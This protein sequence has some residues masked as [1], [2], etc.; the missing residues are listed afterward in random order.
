MKS[1][2]KVFISVDWGTSNFRMRA[3]DTETLQVLGED[4]NHTG[5]RTLYEQVV[6]T[7]QQHRQQVFT[8][9]LRDRLH[10]L[11]G[12]EQEAPLIISGMASS[13]I[14]MLE[15]PYASCPIAVDHCSLQ[16]KQINLWDQR[17]AILVSG[18]SGADGIM[19]G[20]EVQA[21]GL[22]KQ[23][24][25]YDQA[26]LLL[27]GTHS[28]HLIWQKGEFTSFTSFMTGEL[29]EIL[30]RRSILAASIKNGVWTN[31]T[32]ASFM[33]GVKDGF[34]GRLSRSLFKVRVNEVL[35]RASPE[36]GY[37]LLSGLLIG[38]E[39]AHLKPS[40]QTIVLAAT[41]PLFSLYQLALQSCFPEEQLSFC[42]GAALEK[43]LLLGQKKI[44]SWYE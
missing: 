24:Q 16:W 43:A 5:V 35:H 36:Q 27:P 18:V 1:L 13:S 31:A 9:F 12:D 2:P 20:E 39:I 38:D 19:R 40:S 6:G 30:A 4:Q 7:N 10:N 42:D 29:F 41:N 3:V 26:V 34:A 14:G 23:F 37:Y 8:N 28:K 17:M 22:S 11:S 33:E 32:Q 21:L 15:L 44:L 25:S